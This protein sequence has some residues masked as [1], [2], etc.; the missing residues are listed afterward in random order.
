MKAI[1]L[2]LVLLAGCASSKSAY[3]PDGS[4]GHSIDCSGTARSWGM[5]Y[6]KAGELCKEAGYEVVGGGSDRG[7]IVGGTSASFGGGTTI[8]RSM[9]IRCKN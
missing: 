8:S 9:V 6:E 4:K 7:A 1:P 3:L 2:L 5:C